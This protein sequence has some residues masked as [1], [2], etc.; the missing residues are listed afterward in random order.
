MRL[1]GREHSGASVTRA[2]QDRESHHRKSVY[3]NLCTSPLRGRDS[4]VA[5]LAENVFFRYTAHVLRPEIKANVA[6]RLR[7]ASGLM[8]TVR[9]G[10][11]SSEYDIRNS[12]SRLYYAFFHAS[13]AL[14]TTA[15]PDIKTISRTHGSVHSRIQ[16]RLGKSMGRLLRE[17][18]DLRRRSDYESQMFSD[19][20]RD[21]IEEARKQSIVVLKR[22][23][24]NF[25]WLCREADKT[26][27]QS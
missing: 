15:E 16:D 10:S 9:I 27:R 14:L 7:L 21:N 20:F 5:A 19:R 13:L 4:F 22:A 24:T 1:W 6:S 26:L 17:L 2:Q 25:D 23:R 3:A 11:Q 18:Y 12:L 8:S